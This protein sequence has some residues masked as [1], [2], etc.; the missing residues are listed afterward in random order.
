MTVRRLADNQEVD[1]NFD[2]KDLIY[3]NSLL[4]NYPEDK[5][6]SAV[7]PSLFLLRKRQE[8]GYPKELSLL[9]LNFWICQKLEFSKLLHFTQCLTYSLAEITLFKFVEQ[10]LVGFEGLIK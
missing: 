3:L 1:F 7:V 9:F 4:E 8:V 10:L 5:K 2:N 6:Q